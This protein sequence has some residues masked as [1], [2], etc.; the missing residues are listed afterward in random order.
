M[1]K[2]KEIDFNIGIFVF[3]SNLAG[4]HG[5]GAAKRALLGYGAIYG[6]PQGMQGRSYAI[7]T[8][9]HCL[10]P[11][12][13]KRINYFVNKFLKY[14]ALCYIKN[15]SKL[16]LITKIGC[17][18]AGYNPEQIAPMFRTALELP[19]CVLPK[20]FIDILNGKNIK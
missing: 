18:L 1:T 2:I 13:L 20:E 8:K 7:P 16:F 19:N 14:A 11:L 17:G 10:K 9:D 5:A 3:G 6:Q 15:E 4:R 12:P